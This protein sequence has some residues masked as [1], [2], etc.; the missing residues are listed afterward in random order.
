MLFAIPVLF[1]KHLEINSY[2]L[3]AIFKIGMFLQCAF[4]VT[5][6]MTHAKSMFAIQL[7]NTKIEGFD[8][9]TLAIRLFIITDK[10]IESISEFDGAGAVHY[11]Y[12]H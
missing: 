2:Q 3:L 7:V 8:D 9:I 1:D 6:V 5:L 11:M 12:L 10:P 4:V